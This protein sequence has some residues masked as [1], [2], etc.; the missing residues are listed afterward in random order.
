MDALLEEHEALTPHHSP[1]SKLAHTFGPSS[2]TLNVSSNTPE[3]MNMLG[4]PSP[5]SRGGIL[6]PSISISLAGSEEQVEKKQRQIGRAH[7]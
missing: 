4:S 1:E 6:L 2:S 5:S 3:N 7:V